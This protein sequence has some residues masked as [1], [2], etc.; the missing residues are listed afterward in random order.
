MTIMIKMMT[1]NLVVRALST[2]TL[3]YPMTRKTIK[4]LT[5]KPGTK[6]DQMTKVNLLIKMITRRKKTF[7]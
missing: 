7:Q 2:P 5:H 1:G 4:N 6:G 3:I